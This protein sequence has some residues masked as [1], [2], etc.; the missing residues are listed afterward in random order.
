M[1]LRRI[2]I[3]TGL[4]LGIAII[5]PRAFAFPSNTVANPG[6][7]TGDFTSWSNV[8]INPWTVETGGAYAGTKSFVGGSGSTIISQEI[9][10][11]SAGY[12]TAQLDTISGVELSA[13]VKGFTDDNLTG[14]QY[15]LFIAYQGEGF[16]TMA[17]TY[18]PLTSVPTDWTHVAIGLG[19]YGP[20]LRYIRVELWS[21]DGD[22]DG[23]DHGA[24]FDDVALSI[25]GDTDTPT[26]SA[27]SPTD[28]ATSVNLLSNLTLTFN[29]TV[30]A[31]SGNIVIHRLS[32]GAVA[33]TIDAT[34]G[35]V[36]GPG[37]NTI[38]INPTTSLLQGT[39]YYI[40]VDNG[41]F[42]DTW[43]NPYVGISTSTGWN[44]QTPFPQDSSDPSSTPDFTIHDA[45]ATIDAS[46]VAT[47]IWS[48]SSET[49]FIRVYAAKDGQDWERISDPLL[50][51]SSFSW[52]IPEVYRGKN[53]SF[54]V[55]ATDLASRLSSAETPT[56]LWTVNASA[57]SPTASATTPSEGSFVRTAAQDTVY[58]INANYQR[59]P[60]PNAQTFFTWETSFD[61]VQI[62]NAT[63]LS[64]IPMGPPLPPKPG[65]MLIKIT[66]VPKVYVV[67]GTAEHPTLHWIRTE[68]KAI[69]LYG[70]EWTQNVLDVP[71]TSWSSYDV[72]SDIE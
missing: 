26:V 39:A 58:Y 48:A 40:T 68:Q 43:T 10:L 20:G 64:A 33:A 72:G 46:G 62:V 16:G 7:E 49:P 24:M 71:P 42:V 27:L 4:C 14:D 23:A 56:V 67:D 5:V 36:T 25:A 52:Q 63:A 69:E 61:V 29:E 30:Y 8:D 50:P 57:S 17:F 53:V 15:G 44:I 35:A 28:G 19:N 60:I 37:T 47:V 22:G 59:Q 55:E 31:G 34:S 18:V 32:D 66:S 41:A 1:S 45:A 3:I 11:V 54:L 2:I 38:V 21:V 51:T 12:T 6:A 70:A 13:W 9:D 65:T